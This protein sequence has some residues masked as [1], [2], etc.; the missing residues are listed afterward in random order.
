[1]I[2]IFETKVG[3]KELRWIKTVQDKL[4]RTP[5]NMAAV[6]P[7]EFYL[8]NDHKRKTHWVSTFPS[9]SLSFDPPSLAF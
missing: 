1:M 7:R 8:S 6:G 2:E 3:E 5:N 4:I 9:L